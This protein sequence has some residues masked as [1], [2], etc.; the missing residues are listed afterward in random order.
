MA[1]LVYWINEAT[2]RQ[3][4]AAPIVA[5]LAH[6]QFATIHPYHDGN[7]RTARLLATL[8]LHRY[9]YG[10]QGIYA[11]EAHCAQH[12][13]GYYAALTVGESRNYDLYRAEAEVTGF[14]E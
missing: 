6:S 5:A 10:L 8:I 1:D 12:L 4:L 13:Q 9:G 7:G 14:V 3:E 11:L 2:R